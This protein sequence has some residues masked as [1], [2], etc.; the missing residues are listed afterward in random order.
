MVMNMD[1][2]FKAS[3]I[4]VI[5]ASRDSTKVG[6]VILRNLIDGKF[7]GRIYPVNPN[8]EEI[9]GMKCYPSADAIAERVEMAV[10]AV[11]TPF[12]I[13]VLG[14]CAKKGI[15]H[16][17]IISAGFREAGNANGEEK[18]K[19]ALKKYGIRAIGPNCLGTFNSHSEMDTLFLPRYRLKRPE[20]GNI[21]F[22]CQSG[23]VGAAILDMATAQGYG[24]AKFAS[25][26]NAVDVDE[27]DLLEYFGDDAE[28]K[29]ICMYVEGIRDGRKFLEV[30]KRV[31]KKKPVIVLK[32]GVTEQGSRAIASHTG[33]LAGAAEVYFGAFKQA[34][35][36]RADSLYDMF[37]Y[38]RILEASVPAKGGRVQI[39]TNGGGYG[40][41]A[42]DSVAKFGL[43]MAEMTS[44]TVKALKAKFSPA[45]NIGN[46]LDLLGDATTERYKIALEAA[47]NDGNVDAIVLVVLYQTPRITTD[48]IDVITEI[49]ARKKKPMVVVSTGGEFTELLRRNLEMAGIATFEYPEEAV[50]SLGALVGYY[51]NKKK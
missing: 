33:S 9:Q 16:V 41:L 7:K 24:F 21:S 4:A 44:G 14:Q 40:V 19:T 26:G 20:T 45:M 3:S 13:P 39:I 2:F 28:T 25:Y 6:N 8:A 42:S 1:A 37:N 29:V 17:V 43:E 15:R 36:I 30:A 47:I 12:V 10:I 35:V 23:A 32:G 51:G 22:I 46:P 27:S 50:K 38:A 48:V 5:G 11:P 49:N 18:L 34:N 31:S